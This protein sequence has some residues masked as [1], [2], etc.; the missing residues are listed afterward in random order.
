MPVEQ[1]RGSGA[2]GCSGGGGDGGPWGGQRRQVGGAGGGGMGGGQTAQHREMLPPQ[3]G[4]GY[5]VLL[6][7]GLGSSDELFCSFFAVL[8]GIW[9]LSGLYRVSGKRARVELLLFG[10]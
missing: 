1:S 6:P 9:L 2:H 8:I 3:P 4:P 10:E 5:V 7:G